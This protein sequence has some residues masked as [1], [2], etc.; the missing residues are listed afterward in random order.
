ME[1]LVENEEAQKRGRP[2]KSSESNQ[3]AL[4]VLVHIK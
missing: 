2:T 3:K 4:E 1:E